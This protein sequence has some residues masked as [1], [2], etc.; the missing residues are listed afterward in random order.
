MNK[1]REITCDDNKQIIVTSK[2]YSNL[3]QERRQ[4]FIKVTF[5]MLKDYS[6]LY[7]PE[8]STDEKK[9]IIQNKITLNSMQ[10][11]NMIASYHFIGGMSAPSLEISDDDLLYGLKNI[12]FEYQTGPQFTTIYYDMLLGDNEKIKNYKDLVT[13]YYTDTRKIMNHEFIDIIKKSIKT[14]ELSI[15]KL[16]LQKIYDLLDMSM[17]ESFKRNS[18]VLFS[19]IARALSCVPHD[20]T[21][22]MIKEYITGVL[23]NNTYIGLGQTAF[24]FFPLNEADVI[25]IYDNI[26]Y[27][28]A[29]SYI[30]GPNNDKCWSLL[31][32]LLCTLIVNHYKITDIS[33]VIFAPIFT[34]SFMNYDMTDA[35]FTF[36][37]SIGLL[38]SPLSIH[39]KCEWQFK[40][41]VMKDESY[42]S[43][44]NTFLWHA[45]HPKPIIKRK[46]IIFP[47]TNQITYY[48]TQYH[49]PLF[50][51][52]DDHIGVKV[53]TKIILQ[54]GIIFNKKDY[55][56]TN[57]AV[58]SIFE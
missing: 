45:P 36:E 3:L 53:I 23:N 34:Q 54:Y 50:D 18:A 43:M 6:D 29:D 25:K 58:K 52:V 7:N 1:N 40:Q 28:T 42:F 33:H 24:C 5:D 35:K 14:R 21:D 12:I 27:E 49:R 16:G 55:Y 4:V 9:S 47:W 37:N 13:Q 39:I 8:N 2:R 51:I 19:V 48:D 26:S 17:N 46:H 57:Y 10:L 56:N 41:I 44:N 32:R 22:D 38:M 30:V 11:R 31:H 20:W 15:Y